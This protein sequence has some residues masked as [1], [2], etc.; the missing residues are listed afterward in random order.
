MIVEDGSI[1]AGANSYGTVSDLETYWDN[2]NVSLSTYTTAQKEA[3]LI[4]STQYLDNN[5][6][7]KGEILSLEQP[8]DWPR[9]GVY[10]EQGRNVEQT[11]IPFQLT[12]ALFEY[13]YRQLTNSDGLQPDVT[14]LGTLKKKA[15]NLDGGISISKEYEDKTGG[16]FGI[17][18]Y[19]LADNWLKGLTTGGTMG[20][21]GRVRRC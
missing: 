10:D 11:E 6:T 8:L 18:S 13:A 12:N 15:I 9:T 19:P 17:R 3:A 20:D 7:W 1:V 5:F 4:I 14:D 16:Y 21:F 2:R